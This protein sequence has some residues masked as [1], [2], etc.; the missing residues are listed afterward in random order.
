ML[1]DEPSARVDRVVEV[2]DVVVHSLAR[3]S[4]SCR[5]DA[6]LGLSE[7]TLF[8]PLLLCCALLLSS[9]CSWSRSRGCSPTSSEL[10]TYLSYE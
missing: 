6:R 9:R 10:L 2:R 8:V 4:T 1:D 5:R 3:S 7:L